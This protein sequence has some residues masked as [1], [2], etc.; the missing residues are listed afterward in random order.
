MPRGPRLDAVGALHHVMARGIEKREIFL[1]DRDREDLLARLDK[2]VG[3]TGT[4]IFAWC[5]LPNHFHLLL[6]SSS[7]GLST[8]MRRLQT[9]YAVYFNKRHGRAG[10]LFQNRFKSI[11]VE[12]DP[13]L[14]A[15]VRYIHLNPLRA[16]LVKDLRGL[17]GYR[18][19]GHPALLGKRGVPWQ[20]TQYVLAQFGRNA[21]EARAEYRR[22]VKQGIRRGTS[23]EPIEEKISEGVPQREPIE[24]VERESELPV[25]D[26]RVLG[27]SRFVQQVTIG[28]T[29]TVREPSLFIELAER[30]RFLHTLRKEIAARFQITPEELRGGSRQRTVVAAR[31]ALAWVAT[32]VGGVP[33]VD[34]ARATGVTAVS[35]LRVEG[36]GPAELAMRKIDSRRLVQKCK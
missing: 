28:S 4:G 30:E 8:F 6:R 31:A 16:D 19:S 20:D 1:D 17:E 34:V 33:T 24:A 35:V 3:D 12:E 14:L 22:F 25:R 21:R 7:I 36:R 18:W 10:H 29:E 11:L 32:R 27:S 26:T 23:K 5:L 2:L 15:L 13:Y 9:G